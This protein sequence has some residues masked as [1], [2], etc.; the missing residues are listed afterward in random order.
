MPPDCRFVLDANVVVSAILLP[1][2]VPRRAFDKALRTGKI[3]ASDDTIRE[4]DNVL[5]RPSLEKYLKEEDRLHFLAAFLR[6][7]EIVAVKHRI[8]D[9]RDR[10]DN[11]YLELAISASA[12]CIV[13]GDGHLLDLHPYHGIP[14]INPRVFLDSTL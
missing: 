2:S 8:D 12:A 14:I 7:V 3:V 13:T 4:L 5:R 11:R 10:K 6:E 1:G 9:C